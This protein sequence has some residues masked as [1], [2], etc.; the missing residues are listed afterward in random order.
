[1]DQAKSPLRKALQAQG[2]TNS[3]SQQP[4]TL[5]ACD[6]TQG[7]FLGPLVPGQDIASSGSTLSDLKP[8]E[9]V[10]RSAWSTRAGFSISTPTDPEYWAQILGSGW[11]IDW[12][13]RSVPSSS[14]LEYWPM[15]RVHE[16]C[17]SPSIEE[18]QSAAARFPGL[19]WIIGNEPDVIW[20][21]NVKAATYAS[22]YHALYELI[23]SSDPTA[24][25][26]VGGV[27]QST[28]LRLRY[29]DQVLQTYQNLYHQPMPVDWWTVHGYVLREEKGSWGVEIPPGIEATQGE[30]REVSDHGRLDLFEAQI[31]SFREWMAEHGYQQ[32]PLAL[33]EF[34]ILMPSSYGFTTD[35]VGSY[36]EQTFTWLSEVSDEPIGYPEDGYHLVQKWAWF[37]ISDPTYSSSNLGDLSSGKL[38]FVGERFRNTVSSMIH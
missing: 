32:T 19:V 4:I 3:A 18:I 20:Q 25:I 29:L 10:P 36:L 15:V 16:E 14:N 37:S 38:T 23:K 21:D 33:T 28:A 5:H 2:I 6:S 26:A 11:F 13:V 8:N 17:I 27:S 7:S 9:T 31:R 35:V 1:M 24:L 22:I 30:L 34:G 12:S